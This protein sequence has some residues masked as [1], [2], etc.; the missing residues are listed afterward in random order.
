MPQPFSDQPDHDPGQPLAE[1]GHGD[2]PDAPRG[3]RAPLESRHIPPHGD[4]SPDGRRAY[5]RPS[6]LAR[7]IV[8][9]GTGLAAA[10]V[11]AGAVIAARRLVDAVA[12]AR[13]DPPPRRPEASFGP[14]RD[15]VD[16]TAPRASQR[17][18]LMQEIET[19]TAALAGSIDEVMRSV[20]LAATGLRGVVSDA[21]AILR[22]FGDAAELLRGGA[23]RP[24]DPSAPDTSEHGP[25]TGRHAATD[26]PDDHDGPTDH[27]PRVHRL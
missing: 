12:P 8:W 7:W 11:T 4:V 18:G 6:P 21:H 1:S 16:A 15:A 9:G 13:P 3:P 25:A 26:G 22:E 2:A 24:A 19:N 17:P 27:D 20:A 5:P 23:R 10:A 14:R